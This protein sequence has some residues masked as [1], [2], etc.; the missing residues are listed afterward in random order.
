MSVSYSPIRYDFLSDIGNDDSYGWKVVR[1]EMV[2]M[3][4]IPEG[5]R[6]QDGDQERI[7]YEPETGVWMYVLE[8]V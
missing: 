4:S 8:R 2:A 1:K 5:R 7:V 6:V 3:T